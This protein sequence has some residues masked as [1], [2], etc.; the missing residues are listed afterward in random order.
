MNTQVDSHFLL[1][2]ILLTQRQ[3]PDLMPLLHWHS[4]LL[5]YLGSPKV[6]YHI[7]NVINN[8]DVITSINTSI[9]SPDFFSKHI[10]RA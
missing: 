6:A 9:L 1:Q 7:V 2:G 3:N 4:L 5:S 8:E 10:F